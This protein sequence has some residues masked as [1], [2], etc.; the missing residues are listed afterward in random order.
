MFRTIFILEQRPF[1][2]LT[3][4][5]GF[6]VVDFGNGSTGS[7]EFGRVPKKTI[8]RLQTTSL[9]MNEVTI[10]VVKIYIWT[11]SQN[12]WGHIQKSA[13]LCLNNQE[14]YSEAGRNFFFFFFFKPV[15]A[16]RWRKSSVTQNIFTSKL[17]L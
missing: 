10:D 5:H 3:D 17:S 11:A 12:T 13:Q 7:S 2:K 15:A 6:Q 1:D 4:V 9:R 8:T 14:P 16:L